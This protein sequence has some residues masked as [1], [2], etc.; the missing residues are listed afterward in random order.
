MMAGSF[1]R[2]A[3]LA[4]SRTSYG[5]DVLG[6]LEQVDTTIAEAGGFN[7]SY[8]ERSTFDQFGRAFQQFDAAGGDRGTPLV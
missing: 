1:K 7:R 2:G 6:R 8:T 5:C 3:G 4:V